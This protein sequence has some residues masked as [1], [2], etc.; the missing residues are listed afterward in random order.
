MPLCRL[1]AVLFAAFLMT[2]AAG[3]AADRPRLDVDETEPPKT[4]NGLPLLYATGF[5]E[6]AKDV[7]AHWKT[8]DA[9]AWEVQQQGDNHVYALTKKVSDYKPKVRSPFNQAILQDVTVGSCVLDVRLQSTE[10][11]YAH[12]SLCLFF[13]HQDAEHFYYVHF[14]KKTDEHANQIF[15]VNGADRKKISLTST[16]GT[17]WDDNWHTVKVVRKPGDGTIEIYFDDMHQPVMTAKDMTFAHGRIGVGTF[18]DT[19][20]WDDIV[21]RGK[22]VASK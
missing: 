8:T 6:G 13:G 14:G 18:D 1:L 19:A 22:T 12:R 15:I 21:L 17:N 3:R 5:E 16:S 7:A 9:A 11:D 2:A 10:P 4:L 20:D